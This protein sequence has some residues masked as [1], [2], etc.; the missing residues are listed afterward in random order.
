EWG[1]AISEWPGGPNLLADVRCAGRR[2]LDQVPD[3][4][5][6]RGG[7]HS[8]SHRYRTPRLGRTGE[9]NPQLSGDRRYDPGVVR[10]RRLGPILGP[11][12]GH[13]APGEGG[14]RTATART[15]RP[16]TVRPLPHEP[17]RGR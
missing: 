10:R 8:L 6:R 2:L 11:G 5:P 9:A 15:Q 1:A 14:R 16:E 3:R 12:A 4:H 7:P 17:A 13:G